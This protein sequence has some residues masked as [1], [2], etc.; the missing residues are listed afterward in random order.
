MLAAIAIVVAH[1]VDAFT[2]PQFYAEDGAQWFSNAYTFGPIPALGLAHAGYL[3]VISRLGP[4]LAAPF[5]IANQ[6]LIFNICGLLIQIAPVFYFLSS[7]FDSL[8]P[9]FWF[10]AVLSAAYL[11]LPAAELNVDITSAPFHLVILA[12]L[13]IL[14][15]EP[16]RWHWKA[17]DLIAVVLCGFSGP[18]VYILFPVSV[19]WYLIRR[20]RFTLLLAA[21]LAIA[22]V[23]Q[24]AASRSGPRLEA[25]LGAS[26]QNLVVIVCDRIILSGIFAEPGHRHVYVAGRSLG[27]PLASVI[28][29]LA[30]PVVALVVWR[31]PWELKVFGLVAA[32]IVVAGLLAPLISVKGND[33]HIMA[34]S[35]SAARYFFMARV[36]WIVA[37]AW[38]AT[39][40]PRA[41]MSR[42]A[43]AAGAIAFATGLPVWA[44]TPFV[45]YHWPQEARTIEGSAPG[46]KLMLP[47][48]PGSG[49]AV[50]ITVK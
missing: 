8:V 45:D 1:R 26:L 33:W 37:L 21:L 29:V 43:W 31:A 28:C 22:F 15:P 40:L 32:G 27:V 7:R 24:F 25:N 42:T 30:L 19:L 47:I 5:G 23:A 2:T 49:W 6:P 50:D 20:R 13:V 10:R 4:V 46:T 39:Q 9:S 35:D 44:Y 11:L 12:T 3:Q 16:A 38:A 41:W 34:T 36:A 17:F 48:P 18:F 14:A